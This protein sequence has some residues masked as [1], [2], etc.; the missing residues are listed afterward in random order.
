MERYVIH[1]LQYKAN[2]YLDWNA[3]QRNFNEYNCKANI[4]AMEKEEL[5]DKTVSY[6]MLQTLK[7]ITDKEI[8]NL[9]KRTNEYLSSIGNDFEFQKDAIAKGNKILEEIINEC[10]ELINDDSMR[11]IIRHYRQDK[12]NNAKCGSLLVDGKYSYLVCDIVPFMY[13][14][15]G[16]EPKRV[17]EDGNVSFKE[18]ENDLEM[19]IERSPHCYR[20]HGIVKNVVNEN[21]EKYFVS[22]CIYCSTDTLLTKLL[23]YD[24][25]GDVGLA[26]KQK[27]FVD[28][29]KR[30]M[31]TNF[32][33]DDKKR[34]VPLYYKM[35]T[36]SK[37]PI[38]TT[39]ILYGLTDGWNSN[40]MKKYSNLFTLVWNS[41][42][43]IDES[44]LD[45]IKILT[46]LNN[47]E[48]DKAKTNYVPIIPETIAEKIK[49]FKGK[50]KPYFYRYKKNV[51]GMKYTNTSESQISC[52]DKIDAYIKF[53]NIKAIDESVKFSGK[54][55]ASKTFDSIKLEGTDGKLITAKYEE[56]N[57]LYHTYF[58]KDNSNTELVYKKIRQELKIG[59]DTDKEIC[60]FLIKSLFVNR[61]DISKKLLLMLYGDQILRNIIKNKSKKKEEMKMECCVCGTEFIAKTNNSKYCSDK[62]RKAE[63]LRKTK[64]NKKLKT[65]V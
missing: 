33:G 21:T 48:I 2:A 54:V 62:C 3:Y 58:N 9:A 55:L 60:D 7:D 56:I 44:T 53:D 20:E 27:D 47:F 61:S 29:A 12:A 13:H 31:G 35:A 50:S 59:E 16:C 43:S 40:G 41:D 39:S 49:G 25:D 28:I 32:T 65:K 26:I 24:S 10:P 8:E 15:L 23:M 34:I 17:L 22:N 1:R 46:M 37:E 38:N 30:N 63:N 5:E 19:V 36:A 11:D 4:V 57:K 18:Y 42:I 6:Q 52:V 14:L 64:E 51:N 45:F